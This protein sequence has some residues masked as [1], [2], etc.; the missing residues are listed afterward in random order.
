MTQQG[1]TT[2]GREKGEGGLGFRVQGV[3]SRVSGLGFRVE[4]SGLGGKNVEASPF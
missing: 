2:Q 1:P 4:D 3:R